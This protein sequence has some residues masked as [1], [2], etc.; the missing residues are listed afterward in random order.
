M[1]HWPGLSHGIV[2]DAVFA[3][4][5]APLVVL[6][7]GANLGG[8]SYLRL[9]EALAARGYV[10]AVLHPHGSPGASE[11]RYAAAAA[12]GRTTASKRRRQ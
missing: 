7:P 2:R 5:A 8:A 3:G 4:P 12:S 10:V 6:T 9:A 1:S 11:T